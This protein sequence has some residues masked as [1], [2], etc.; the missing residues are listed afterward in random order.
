MTAKKPAPKHHHWVPR[1]YLQHFA[2]PESRRSKTPRVYVFDKNNTGQTP[3]PT[4]VKEVCVRR[5]L[6]APADQNGLRDWALEVA[7]DKIE[8]KLGHRWIE[9]T[10]GEPS[11]QDE[12]LRNE[13]SLFVATLHLRNPD[14]LKTID[15][16]MSLRNRLYG[17]T[18]GPPSA[19]E[20]CS[21]QVLGDPVDPS[22]RPDPTDPH[23][24]FT[25]MVWTQAGAIAK[26][27]FGMRWSVLCTDEDVFVTSD[28]P[29]GFQHAQRL[30]AGPL[31]PGAL[32][33]FPINPRRML[34][35]GDGLK[36]P[37]EQYAKVSALVARG[38]NRV[39]E[40]TSTRFVFTGR[41]GPEV[42]REIQT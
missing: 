32:T 12:S 22:H 14:I 36:P 27:F 20:W 9:F 30:R 25:H 5:Y 2:T 11:L 39:Q 1:S 15:T 29:V 19:S 8:A 21:P 4:S 10:E 24:F 16:I 13:L 40:L 37:Y 6:Y 18:Q 41:S 3:R 38:Y 7:L 31:T 17:Q 35:L 42:F 28:R 26:A 33:I 23:R 34:L